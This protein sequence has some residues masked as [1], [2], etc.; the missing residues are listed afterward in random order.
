MASYVEI[1]DSI[2]DFLAERK[3]DIGRALVAMVAAGA[4]FGAGYWWFVVR[5]QPPPSIFDSPVDDVL[6]YLTMDDFSKLPL[7]ERM[8]FLMDFADR[9]RGMAQSESVLMSGFLAGLSGPTREQLTQNARELA[10]DI[11]AEGAAAYVNLKPEEREKFLDD[12][13][14]EWLRTGER[15]ATGKAG[16]EP[17]V[18][19]VRNFKEDAKKDATRERNPNRIPRLTDKGASRFLDFYES[20]VQ[21]TAS[22]KEQGQITRFMDD[23][24]KHVLK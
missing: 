7:K 4:F 19:R 10:K 15:L 17:D 2:D 13:L 1:R 5:W 6:G 22:P 23:L 12:W 3:R 8:Q 21:Q 18:D 11:L 20:D 14:A 24:R 9:F 16:D